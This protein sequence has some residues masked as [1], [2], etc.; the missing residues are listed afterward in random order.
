MIRLSKSD[1]SLQEK[2][3]VIKVLTN[4]FLGMGEEV[5]NFESDLSSY[6]DCPVACVSNGT[7]ALHLSLQALGI[8]PGD[9]VL[10][11]TITYV[12][13]FQAIS[14]TGAKP[15][16]CDIDLNT[17]TIDLKDAEKRITDRTKA[18][19]LVHYAG[20]VGNLDAAYQFAK[21][22]GL[23]VIEDAAHAFGSA[24]L[25]CPV[26]SN[27]DIACFSFDGIK[28]IT[29]GEGGCVVTKDANILKKIQ[30]TR[31]LGV[32]NDTKARFSNSRSWDF[33]VKMQGW[34]Y[35]MSDIMAAIGRVQLKRLNDF[36][37]TRR[38]LARFYD[39]A[40]SKYQRISF[41]KQDYNSVVPHIYPIRISGLSLEDR[42]QLRQKLEIN[43]IQIGVHYKPNHLL[44]FFSDDS[45]NPR[46]KAESIYSE[47][48][49]LPLHTGLKQ[50]DIEYVISNLISEIL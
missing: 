25:G 15:I 36:S 27:A 33:D 40:L 42:E 50:V 10:V 9:E 34:R 37:K 26:G 30:D 31:L 4:E 32:E 41:I 7:A 45:I 22:F 13:S 38:S 44:S 39:N 6:F 46:Y 8:G 48:L 20:G 1:I 14:A 21:N 11:Q 19:M 17:L 16:A 12:A 5:R 3:A 43:G 23:R 29:S 49:S 24:Y 2:N 18:I 35:H 28:N 47:L